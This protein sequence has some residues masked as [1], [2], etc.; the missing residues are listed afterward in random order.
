MSFQG[1][2]RWF[3]PTAQS[4]RSVYGFKS[5]LS[6]FREKAIEVRQTTG[7]KGP[8]F[9]PFEYAERL[10]ISVEEREGMSI[11]GLLKYIDGSFVV[12]L[13]KEVFP[14]RKNFTLAHEIAHTFFYGL[15]SHPNSFRGSVSS[16]PEEERLC[17]AAAAELLMPS[18]IFR[19]ELLTVPNV[20]PQTLFGLVDRYRV[21]LQSVTIRTADVHAGLACAFWRREGSAINLKS[22]A[23]TRLR[24]L[25][26]CQT[27]H[28]SVELAFSKPGKV[29]TRDDFFYGTESSGRIRRKVS[30]YCFRPNNA[31]SV[32]EVST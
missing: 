29:F 5:P 25:T 22:I 21:S 18:S 8:P 3:G 16:D 7:V 19:D 30:S 31:I 23:P 27:N 2:S 20:T 24:N 28:S 6:L 10:S 26:L 9:D 32:I 17:D 13:K 15:L 1:D 14:L 4:L 11:D 12:Y